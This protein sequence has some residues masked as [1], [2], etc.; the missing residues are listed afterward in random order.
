MKNMKN[1][2]WKIKANKIVGALCRKSYVEANFLKSGKKRKK[3]VPYSVP[4]E[5]VDL[6]RFVAR[7]DEHGAKALMMHDYAISKL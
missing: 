3:H 1:D 4:Q 5:A 7:N 6:L 2:A